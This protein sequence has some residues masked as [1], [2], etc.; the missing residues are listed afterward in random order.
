[1]KKCIFWEILCR[2]TESSFYFLQ[3]STLCFHNITSYV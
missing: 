1:M 3:W 2:R